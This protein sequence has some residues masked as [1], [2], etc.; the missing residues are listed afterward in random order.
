MRKVLSLALAI[1]MVLSLTIVAVGAADN[2]TPIAG[3]T[4]TVTAKDIKGGSVSQTYSV[5]ETFTVW[6]VLNCAEINDGVMGSLK[7]EQDYDSAYLQLVD[8]YGSDGMISDLDSMF[9]I[10]KS[11]TV[12]NGKKIGF[13]HYNAST[14]GYSGFSAP[15]NSDESYLI[16]ANYKV[17]AAGETTIDNSMKTLAI[18]DFTLTRVIDRGEIKND[19]FTSKCILSE[20]AAPTGYTL[21]GKV[22]S[23]VT[24][25]EEGS[26]YATT[27][28][29]LQGETV[30]KTASYDT[31]AIFDYSFDGV[32]EGAYTLRISKKNHVTRDYEVTV[33]GDTTQ[34]A[35]I[36][37]IGDISGDGKV[38]NFDYARANSHAKGKSTLTGYEFLCGDVNNDGKVNTFDAGRIN[39]MGKGKSTLWT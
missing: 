24:T 31:A 23:Y 11:T 25:E 15:F 5:G 30:V 34:D 35:K 12:A 37:P 21:S 13:I 20:P 29:L 28:E 36:H 38:N 4:L 33:S 8:E 32:A 7:G 10:T 27:V 16:V 39:S 3:G 2:D 1:V 9:P 19:S 18:A 14:P 26:N 17:V 22:T 6:T